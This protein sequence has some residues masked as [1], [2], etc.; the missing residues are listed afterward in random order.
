MPTMNPKRKCRNGDTLFNLTLAESLAEKGLENAR[1]RLKA[2]H[3]S[4]VQ[5]Q[6]DVSIAE[7]FLLNIRTR[8]KIWRE[9]QHSERINRWIPKRTQAKRR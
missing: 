7:G 1:E 3:P 4:Y 6:A 2:I 8:I 9:D 5:A